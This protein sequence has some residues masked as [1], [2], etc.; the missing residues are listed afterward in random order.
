LN[1]LILQQIF[2]LDTTLQK[3]PLIN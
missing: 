1:F 3:N 2:N